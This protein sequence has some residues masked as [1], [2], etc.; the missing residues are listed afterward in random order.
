MP[1]KTEEKTDRIGRIDRTHVRMSRSVNS[2]ESPCSPDCQADTCT[3]NVIRL[4]G[5][6]SSLPDRSGRDALN[7]SKGLNAKAIPNLSPGLGSTTDDPVK[8]ETRCQG[9]QWDM[10]VATG[11]PITDHIGGVHVISLIAT[12]GRAVENGQLALWR[13]DLKQEKSVVLTALI[14]VRTR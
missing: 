9:K 12:L 10:K 8:T 3:S 13:R 7:V 1:L 2:P 5:S 4:Y 11:I 6:Q 14:L